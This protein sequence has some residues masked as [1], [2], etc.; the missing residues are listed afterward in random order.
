MC[1]MKTCTKCKKEKDLSEFRARNKSKD[2]KQSQCRVCCDLH[3][4][5]WYEKNK[6]KYRK[7]ATI[8]FNKRRRQSQDF[9]I[10][11]LKEHPCVDCSEA[12]ILVLDFDHKGG[13]EYSIAQMMNKNL[14][15][16]KKEINKCDVRCANCHRIR[17]AKQF[18]WYKYTSLL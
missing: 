2:K 9:L 15:V 6:T 16:I 12:N 7:L 17:T 10:A 14:S 4:K 11:F 5:I 3:K 18:N 1:N 8:W 13:K